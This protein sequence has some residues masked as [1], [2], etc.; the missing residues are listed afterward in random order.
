MGRVRHQPHQCTN[1][2]APVNAVPPGGTV[3]CTYCGMV[4]GFEPEAPELGPAGPVEPES[5][6]GSAA[7]VP[8][9]SR[10]R[11]SVLLVAVL[12]AVGVGAMVLFL[13]LAQPPTGTN[14]AAGQCPATFGISTA[15]DC[16][17]TRE[18]SA[19]P[20]WGTDLYTTDSDVCT[21]AVHAGA[22]PLAG[23][24]VRVMA[25]PGCASY[26]GTARNGITTSSWGSYGGSF[27]FQGHGTG[28]CS[29]AAPPGDRCPPNYPTDR[30]EVECL[31][32]PDQLS[33]SVWGTDVYTTDSSLCRA[34]LHAGATGAQGGR[35]RAALLPG[36]PAYSGTLRNGV[37]TTAWGAYA[38]S[39]H[40]PGFG[41]GTCE[42]GAPP[43]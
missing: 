42:Q 36:C 16:V 20:V 7:G 9:H 21:A 2:G 26:L 28:V 13:G 25:A 10:W 35:V 15:L 39:F 41:V 23:G 33:G 43:E 8:M 29:S 31:C 38:S 18:Q 22:I 34:A 32:G 40:F 24:K 30:P 1:C 37:P 12:L 19:G 5:S 4:L 3:Q 14:A 6:D 11:G 17:C 27:R